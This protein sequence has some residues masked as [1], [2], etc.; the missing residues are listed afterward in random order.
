MN[1]NIG[2]GCDKWGDIRVDIQRFSDI[3]YNK[4]TSANV[5]ADIQSLPFK[6]KI[7]DE[8]RCFHV[9]EHVS[10]PKQALKELKRV[11]KGRIIIRVPIWHLYSYIAEAITLFKAFLLIPICGTF[12]FTDTLRKIKNWKKRY[13]DHKWYI[14]FK[15]SKINKTYMLL[16]KEYEVIL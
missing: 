16:P 8:T 1:L 9:L 7:F 5:I 4:K 12:Y 15:N 6:P 13:G 10:N 14:K 11:T 2:C 3:F